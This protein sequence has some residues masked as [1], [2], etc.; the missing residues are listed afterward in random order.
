MSGLAPS[1]LPICLQWS[2]G[3]IAGPGVTEIIKRLGQLPGIFHDEAAWRGLD[4]ETEV[5]RVRSWMP[6]PPGTEG[7]LF[8][9]STTLRPGRVGDEFFMTHGHFHANRDRGEYYATVRGKGVLVLMDDARQTWSQEMGPGSVHYIPGR[10]GHRVVNTGDEPLVFLA[11][12]P[13]DAGHDYDTILRDG[14][15]RRMVLRDGAPC[16]V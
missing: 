12:W 1:V 16:L 4:P 15:S 6:V 7:G 13:S 10:V 14:F 3:E 9:G 11:T 8:W 2:T 5:Y